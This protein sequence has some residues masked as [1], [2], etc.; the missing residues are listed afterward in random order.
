[1]SEVY[2]HVLTAALRESDGRSSKQ[3]REYKQRRHI[4]NVDDGRHCGDIA[5]RDHNQALLSRVQAKTS[6]L[7]T[8]IV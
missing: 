5:Y 3:N 7:N 1:M 4:E 6:R 8:Y 2:L